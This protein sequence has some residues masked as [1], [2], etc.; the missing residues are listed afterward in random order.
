MAAEPAAAVG[1]MAEESGELSEVQR[2][3]PW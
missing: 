3:E 1:V 2:V